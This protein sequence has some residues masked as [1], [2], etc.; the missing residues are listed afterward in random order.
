MIEQ[1]KSVTVRSVLKTLFHGKPDA[2]REE[3]RNYLRWGH[4]APSAEH[5]IILLAAA[6]IAAI[7]MLVTAVQADAAP[8]PGQPVKAAAEPVT[9]VVLIAPLA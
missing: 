6:A 2:T 7:L 3:A 9:R 5:K 4:V 1:F 8:R